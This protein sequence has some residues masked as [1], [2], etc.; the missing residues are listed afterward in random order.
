M[1]RGGEPCDVAGG[2]VVVLVGQAGRVDEVTA[3]EAHFLGRAVHQR[4]KGF[5][6]AGQVLGQRHGGVVAGLHDHALQQVFHRDLLADL[7][8]HARA[9]GAPG[10]FADGD[11]VGQL[12]MAGFQFVEDR[13]R[14]SSAW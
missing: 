5:L 9:R 12:D 2:H 10:L 8:E 6:A 7:D 4:G 11:H 13:R 14:P 1:T 3:L